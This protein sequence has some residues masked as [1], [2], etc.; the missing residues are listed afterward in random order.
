MQNCQL[1]LL[2]KMF[3]YHSAQH[4]IKDEKHADDKITN[5]K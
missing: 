4:H 1:T 3:H 2:V 5:C